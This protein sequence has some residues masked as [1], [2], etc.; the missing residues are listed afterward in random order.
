MKSMALFFESL[1]FS[2]VADKVLA[3]RLDACKMSSVFLTIWAAA[4]SI[5]DLEKLHKGLPDDCRLLRQDWLIFKSLWLKT[6]EKPAGHMIS[7]PQ[8]DRVVGLVLS[9][10]REY[11][12]TLMWYYSSLLDDGRKELDYCSGNQNGYQIIYS[13]TNRTGSGYEHFDVEC[14]GLPKM[15]LGLS[16]EE[17]TGKV[18]FRFVTK[19]DLFTEELVFNLLQLPTSMVG[20]RSSGYRSEHTYHE[21]D[22]CYKISAG[23]LISLTEMK[24]VGVNEEK[25]RFIMDGFV[26]ALFDVIK[27]IGISVTKI[28]PIML[29]RAE[30][31][32]EN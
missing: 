28:T 13:S 8:P 14:D 10:L 12:E 29:T 32:E 4:Q 26:E 30:M 3:R 24:V 23:E 25:Y 20:H 6:Q 22:F 11:S 16:L 19:N 2:D 9:A 17:K 31:E 1:G 27:G 18:I 21:V 7:R 5:K 15:K